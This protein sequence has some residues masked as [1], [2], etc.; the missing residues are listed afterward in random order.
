MKFR[1]PQLIPL[2]FIIVAFT[3]LAGLGAW[4]V[5]RLRWKNDQI[6][7]LQNRQAMPILG[8]LPQ[9][10]EGLDFRSVALTGTY[11]N[12]KTMH[13]MVCPHQTG[14]GYCVLTPFSLEDDG[15]VI[16]VSRGFSLAGRE[17]APEGLQTLTGI[18]R[19]LREKRY[20]S[21]ANNAEKNAW[22]YE[23][24][25]AM[26]QSTGIAILPFVVEATGPAEKDVYPVP[27]D[28]KISLRN[29]HLNYAVTWFALA[30]IALVM[31]GFYH[32]IPPQK[33]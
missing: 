24:I 4:Q 32:R 3:V 28:G 7:A 19:P 33:P 8:T 30:F 22:F 1:K 27:N 16:L 21:P 9:E 15:R 6:V 5:E 17:T 26:A 23:D 18:I 25:P 29:D 2:L 14:T 13:M 11:L 20:F 10:L 12:D 31:F